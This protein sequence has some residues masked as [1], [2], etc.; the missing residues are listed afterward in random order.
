M[1]KGRPSSTPYHNCPQY[2]QEGGVINCKCFISDPGSP[3]GKLQWNT[4]LSSELRLSN[5]QQFDY[6]M[7]I[8]QLLWN[9]T[10]VKSVE[11]VLKKGCKSTLL[12]S[13]FPNL[14]SI[15]FLYLCSI[16]C[17][18][19]VYYLYHFVQQTLQVCQPSI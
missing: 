18:H 9:N 10:V 17:V 8:C 7:Y 6:G 2:V 4:T 13:P 19:R 12:L 5:V 14:S 11:Y 3:P 1:E 15:L 16:D